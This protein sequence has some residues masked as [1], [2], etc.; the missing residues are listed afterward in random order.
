VGQ[1]KHRDPF[2]TSAPTEPKMSAPMNGHAFPRVAL[3]IVDD[4]EDARELLADVVRNAGYTVATASDG[5]E[6]IEWLKRCRPDLIL[7]DV[8]MPGMDGATFRQEQ[9]R[10]REW[11]RIPTIV[12]TGVADEPVLDV[13]IEDTLRKPIGAQALLE[14]VARHCAK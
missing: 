1:S 5:R 8:V 3:L 6:A 4:N 7:L 10:N 11:I 2:E 9:R 12:M 13:A 14:L